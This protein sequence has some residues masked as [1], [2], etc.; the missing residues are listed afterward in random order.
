MESNTET[1]SR[2][3]L[4]IYNLCES[5]V[6]KGSGA[7]QL[8]VTAGERSEPAD[9]NG[10]FVSASK[11]SNNSTDV[12]GLLRSPNR[13]GL[14]Y[15]RFTSFTSGYVSLGGFTALNTFQLQIRIIY[16][17]IIIVF[18]K[19]SNSK[20]GLCEFCLLFYIYPLCLCVSIIFQ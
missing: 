12:I 3:V 18:R 6:G 8:Y 7:V 19:L 15:R 4:F 10:I 5:G 14:N 2:S 13:E 11:R 1:Q 17:L 9:Y 20:F 16:Y